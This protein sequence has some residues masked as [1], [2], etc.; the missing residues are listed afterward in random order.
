MAMLELDITTYH[1]ALLDRQL[2]SEQLVTFYLDRIQRFDCAL[3]SIISI[4]S[5][6][7]EL[8][9]KYDE[10]LRDTGKLC[11]S[12]HGIPVLIKDNIETK[13]L[14]TTAGSLS[15]EGFSTGK[16]ADLVKRLKKAG[17]IILAKT[18]LHEFAIWGESISSIKGQTLNPYDLT[19]T[20]GGSSGGT[21]AALAANFGMVGIGTDTINS[22][23]SPSSANNLVGIRPT[24]G[25]VSAEGIVPYSLTQDTAGPMARTLAD[26]VA[27]LKVISVRDLPEV[28][29]SGY[30]RI[31]VLKSFFG[32]EP[33]NE[34]VNCVMAKA[35]TELKTSGMTLV[36]IDDNV[37]IDQLVSKVSVHLYELKAHL[38]GYLERVG[39]PYPSIDAILESG[40]HHPGIKDNLV[41]TNHL[42]IGSQEYADR[43]EKR[44]KLQAQI[45]SLF[46]DH[47][48][49]ALVFPHQ[50]RL[51]CQVGGSQIQRNGALSAIT[52]F[53]SI[54]QPAGFSTP[55]TDAPIGVPIG[56]ELLGLPDT[57][58]LLIEISTI[59]QEQFS[60]R[61]PPIEANWRCDVL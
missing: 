52:G 54:C 53:P 51:V 2:T 50:Q 12:L 13:E 56:F 11:G 40:L 14:P 5:D 31:G 3:S 15:L 30:P 48:L 58:P 8:A 45:R 19:R 49:D 41:L 17:A 61:R 37:S 55:T 34:E 38:N 9:R 4:N 24:V 47:Q 32:S 28:S 23:R 42:D 44:T 26:A 7:I 10:A 1:Q 46:R 39:A 22:I 59:Y 60:K 36:D 57:E 29:L 25:L 33:I 18:N 20:P 6:A 27:V 35:L 16:D 43:M 21:G